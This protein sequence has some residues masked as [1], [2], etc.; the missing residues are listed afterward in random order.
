MEL[1]FLGIVC[2]LVL[3]ASMQYFSRWY[4]YKRMM[5]GNHKLIKQYRRMRDMDK[6]LKPNKYGDKRPK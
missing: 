6:K 3:Y 1:Y 2:G 4:S 5:A